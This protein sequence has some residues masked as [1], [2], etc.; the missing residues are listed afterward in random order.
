MSHP[1][2]Q[3]RGADTEKSAALRSA[4]EK[5]VAEDK[6]AHPPTEE[7]AAQQRA[8]E[9]Q[10]R[11]ENRA[12]KA[13]EKRLA[14][15]RSAAHRLAALQ[16]YAQVEQFLLQVGEIDDAII[17]YKNCR[18]FSSVVRLVSEHRKD[19]LLK[20]HL[21]IGE[22]LKSEGDHSLAEYHY[23]KAAEMSAAEKAADSYSSVKVKNPHSEESE[24]WILGAHFLK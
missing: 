7:H 17:M 10:S 24:R 8:S 1:D 23:V 12:T 21:E 2:D 6:A 20:T 14:L 13:R 5:R 9:A 18:D 19:L 22:Q 15:L 11:A 16:G 3:K 4:D